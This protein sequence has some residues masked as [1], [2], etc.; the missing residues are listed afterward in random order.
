MWSLFYKL[1]KNYAWAL[2]YM[3]PIHRLSR[4]VVLTWY[5]MSAHA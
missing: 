2:T 4:A 1:N 5:A 3:I